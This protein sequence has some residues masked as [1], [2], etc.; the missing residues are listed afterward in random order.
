[1]YRFFFPKNATHKALIL[2]SR[3][4]ET[5]CDDL[6]K[7][8]LRILVDTAP[9]EQEVYLDEEI[10]EEEAENLCQ[11]CSM[12]NYGPTHT[13]IQQDLVEQLKDPERFDKIVSTCNWLDVEDINKYRNDLKSFVQLLDWRHGV[14]QDKI[15]RY[16]EKNTDKCAGKSKMHSLFGGGAPILEKPCRAGNELAYTLKI[17]VPSLTWEQHITFFLDNFYL[18]QDSRE[19]SIFENGV[20]QLLEYFKNNWHCYEFYPYRLPNVYEYGKICWGDISTPADLR[21]A[22]NEFYSAAFN[23]DLA[24]TQN[25]EGSDDYPYKTTY[26]HL[27]YYR[28]GDDIPSTE[29]LSIYTND[30]VNIPVPKEAL[31]ILIFENGKYRANLY[32]TTETSV[33]Y[34]TKI[35]IVARFTLAFITT[36]DRST[37]IVDIVVPFQHGCFHTYKDIEMPP[38]YSVNAEKVKCLLKEYREYAKCCDNYTTELEDPQE[39]LKDLIEYV[40]QHHLLQEDLSQL[41]EALLEELKEIPDCVRVREIVTI[42][43]VAIQDSLYK[44]LGELYK[45]KYYEVPQHAFIV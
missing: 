33:G 39:E 8:E 18:G 9:L 38:T 21:E 14:V 41:R 16:Y 6:K 43:E 22:Q 26:E 19:F 11:N 24:P 40:T 37:N 28:G 23:K 31:G 13:K 25:R 32:S 3:N 1:M 2:E 34:N 15:K 17:N 5:S 29:N 20:G 35:K 4:I 36:Y 12:W 10:L 27:K 45:G 44:R 30:V 7:F 42:I